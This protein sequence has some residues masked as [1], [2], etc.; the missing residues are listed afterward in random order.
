MF[1]EAN[2]T[3]IIKPNEEALK[4]IIGFWG[5]DSCMIVYNLPNL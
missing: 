3:L 4:K 2:G 5:V 1:Y